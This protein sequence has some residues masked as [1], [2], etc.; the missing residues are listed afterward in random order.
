MENKSL[1]LPTRSLMDKQAD[2][3]HTPGLSHIHGSV[4]GDSHI[5]ITI[6][7]YTPC[8]GVWSMDS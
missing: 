7:K 4:S 8:T 6:D 3:D 5:M 1:A 2:G